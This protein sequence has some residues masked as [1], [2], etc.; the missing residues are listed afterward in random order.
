M[1]IENLDQLRAAFAQQDSNGDS[2]PNNYYPFWNIPEGSQA[3]IRFLPDKNEENRLGF[4]VEKRM[5]TL[6]INGEDKSIPC[7]TTYGEECP[8]CKV[9]SSYYKKEDKVNGKKYW[10]KKQHLAQAIVVDDPL[11]VDETTGENHEGKVRFVALGYQLYNIIKEAFES[12]ELDEIPFA[13]KGGTDFIIK[14]SKQGEYATYALGSKFARKSRDLTDDEV[15]LAEEHMV[16][17][18]TLLPQQPD[19]AKVEEMLAAATGAAVP[20]SEDTGGL[21]FKRKTREDASD[22][23]VEEAA[24]KVDVATSEAEESSDDDGT[25]DEAEALLSQIRSRRGK[26]AS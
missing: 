1:A 6:S 19:L 16:D 18:S 4:L 7:L 20:V 10:R 13:F 2:R 9:S 22:E 24:V 5:H 26:K 11:P 25:T 14:K 3:V 21:N 23:E 17:L 12:G 15:A 8:I